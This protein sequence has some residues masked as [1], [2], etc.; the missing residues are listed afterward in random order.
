MAKSP[1]TCHVLDSSTGKPAEGIF[2]RLQQF[3][4]AK[5]PGGLDAF[6]PLAKGY[7]NAD[8]R[9][10]DL[11]PPRGSEL[12][13]EEK[14]DPVAGQ[15][16]KLVFKTKEYFER[17]NRQTFYPWVEITFTIDNP[18]EHYHVPLLISPYSFTTYR[19]S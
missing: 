6:R 11:L 10:V 18:E 5:E 17:T 8:G 3:E 13:T 19:G 7:T 2:I 12:A 4:P 9:C 15:I 16:Y 14:T 1:I